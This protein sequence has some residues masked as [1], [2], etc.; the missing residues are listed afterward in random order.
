MTFRDR[1]DAGRR[2]AEA[3]QQT[4]PDLGDSI[5]VALPRGG[6]PVGYEVAQALGAPLDVLIVRKIGAPGHPE[7]G[8]GAVVDGSPP[9]VVLNS[10]V[11]DIVKPSQAHVDA[12]TRRQIEEL[13]RRRQAYVGDGPPL[14]TA[15]RTVILVDDGIA[16]GGTV[17][18]ALRGLARSRAARLVLVVPLA[19]AEILGP[20][21]AEADEVVCLATP[22]PF[23]AVGLHYVDFGQT[24][25]EEVIALLAEARRPGLGLRS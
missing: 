20:L 7:L 10:S 22:D 9:Q 16:T 21:R 18:A 1:R 17:R 13:E 5:V 8:L 3:L 23:I 19:P 11:M 6:V 4:V 24:T 15:D 14:A 2:L 25:D 12:E